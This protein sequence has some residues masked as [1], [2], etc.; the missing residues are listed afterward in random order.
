MN[1]G[2]AGAGSDSIAAIIESS[3]G[4]LN[5]ASK[6]GRAGKHTYLIQY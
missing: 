5:F 2:V 3:G 4:D 6:F 1:P